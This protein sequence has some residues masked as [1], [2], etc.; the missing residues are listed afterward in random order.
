MDQTT[1]EIIFVNDIYSYE[2]ELVEK[3]YKAGVIF[4][5]VAVV[6]QTKSLGV[7]EAMKYLTEKVI[8]LEKQMQNLI[9]IALNDPELSQGTKTFIE[10]IGYVNGGHFNVYKNI[11]GRY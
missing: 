10:R 4:N 11:C 5:A 2:K 8:D 6:M 7:E 1:F 9:K 3:D